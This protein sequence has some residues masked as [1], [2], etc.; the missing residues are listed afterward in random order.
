VPLRH[1]V[2]KDGIQVFQGFLDP[3]FRLGDGLAEFCKQLLKNLGSFSGLIRDETNE[4]PE[5]G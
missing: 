2:A 1:S 5:R 4:N 3:G